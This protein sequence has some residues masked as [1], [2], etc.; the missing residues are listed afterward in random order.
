ML[1]P[2]LKKETLCTVSKPF[3]TKPLKRVT[4]ILYKLHHIRHFIYKLMSKP[5]NLN[6]LKQKAS[7]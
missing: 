4:F 3:V 7:T 2:S 1:L 5:E 6:L